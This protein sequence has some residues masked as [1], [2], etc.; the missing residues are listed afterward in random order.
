MIAAMMTIA[1]THVSGQAGRLIVTSLDRTTG[2]M[3]AVTEVS[4]TGTVMDDAQTDIQAGGST[5]VL[6]LT[7]DTWGPT[8]GGDNQITTFLIFGLT[9][10]QSE[11]TGW[12]A[13]VRGRLPSSAVDRTSA[14][15]VTLTLPAF[16]AY[17][18]T[19]NETITVTI[20]A[21]ALVQSTTVVVATPTLTVDF[22]P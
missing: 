13:A 11:A 6:T 19:A 21:A 9:S 16:A 5:I 20:P 8:V 3:Q 12:N 22:L 14:T 10:A 18:I 15:V 7:D 4:L 2:S 1:A 17:A